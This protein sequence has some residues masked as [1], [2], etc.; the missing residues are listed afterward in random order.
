[1]SAESCLKHPW[2]QIPDD[3]AQNDDDALSANKHKRK[4]TSKSI[5]N[6]DYY[7]DLASKTM[8]VAD[9]GGDDWEWEWYET[10]PVDKND[11][12]NEKPASSSSLTKPKERS[13]KA[14]PVITHQQVQDKAAEMRSPVFAQIK[15]MSADCST[16]TASPLQSLPPSQ[17]SDQDQVNPPDE[18]DNETVYSAEIS[19]PVQIVLSKTNDNNSSNMVA[20]TSEQPSVWQAAER[21]LSPPWDVSKL[22][23]NSLAQTTAIAE[24]KPPPSQQFYPRAPTPPRSFQLQQQHPHHPQQQRQ[25]QQPQPQ[26]QNNMMPQTY[27]EQQPQQNLKPLNN[28][29]LPPRSPPQRM[30]SIALQQQQFH[31]PMPFQPSSQF[32]MPGPIKQPQ[33]QTK[34]SS[35]FQPQL[36]FNQPIQPTAAASGKKR[37]SDDCSSTSD[38]LQDHVVEGT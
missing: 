11:D 37:R 3:K 17:T 7:F 14:D 13:S 28:P 9:D 33:P 35:N 12:S 8:S 21:A 10:Q 34:M 29:A 4:E 32:Q 24:V 15:T 25:L 26:Q 18:D 19:R 27:F 30:K 2:L 16:E 36:S 38:T 1:M 23:N 22:T 6:K 5:S 31:Q 20:E